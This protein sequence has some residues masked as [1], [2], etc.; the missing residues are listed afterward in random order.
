VSITNN[1]PSLAR[2]VTLT[3]QLPVEVSL[4]GTTI[5]NGTGTCVLLE[6]PPNTVSCQLNDL[7]PGESVLV[8]IDVLVDPSV[9][10]GTTITNSAT[11]STSAT[12][13]VPGN[14]T[15]TEDTHVDAVADLEIQKDGNFEANNPSSTIIYTITVTN[16]GPSD[17]LN[18]VMVDTLPMQSDPKKARYVFDTGNG[19]CTYPLPAPH[20]VT[21]DFGTLAAGD[22]VSVDILVDPKG[23]LGVI[24]NIADVTTT[25]FDP[26]TSNNTARKDMLVQGGSGK[27]GGPG[28][29]RGR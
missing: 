9:P 1:G 27:P 5:S 15:D 26:D 18:V 14:N 25:T 8:Y 12:D 13:P 11:A 22:T 7:D 29:G 3:D 28:G 20:S 10:D 24:T 23:G 4:T 2:D 17:A 6:V 19:A 16:H 21:C